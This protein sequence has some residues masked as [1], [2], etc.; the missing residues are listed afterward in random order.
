MKGIADP[1]KCLVMMTM[2]TLPSTIRDR[3]FL[4]LD[5]SLDL[6][7]LK[8]KDRKKLCRVKSMI[9]IKEPLESPLEKQ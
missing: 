9:F 1:T 4:D 6:K 5:L 3:L 8:S 7:A 2:Q